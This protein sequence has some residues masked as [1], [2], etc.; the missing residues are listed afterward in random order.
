MR[1]HLLGVLSLMLAACGGGGAGG[2]SS[3][4]VGSE[5]VDVAACIAGNCNLSANSVAINSRNTILTVQNTRSMEA[6]VTL[7]NVGSNPAVA[8]M[9]LA[10]GASNIATGTLAT[11]TTSSIRLQNNVPS[12]V[13][14][15]NRKLASLLNNGQQA[16]SATSSGSVVQA[17]G[18]P[19]GPL[20]VGTSVAS[21]NAQVSDADAAFSSTLEGQ[22][23]LGNGQSVNVWVAANSNISRAQAQRMADIF[24]SQ[25]YNPVVALAGEPW[26]AV[27]TVAQNSL[28]A[29]GARDIHIV[30]HDITPDAQPL[31][32]I[33]Y[34]WGIN[35]FTR[36]FLLQHPETAALKSNEQL[37]FFMDSATYGYAG[38]PDPLNSN[39]KL[40]WSE[41]NP[42]P[43]IAIT[44]LAHEF[45]HMVQ[46][47]QK[48][49]RHAANPL[50]VPADDTWQNELASQTLA[51]VLGQQMYANQ[52]TGNNDINP[53]EMGY[54][55]PH[56][57]ASGEFARSLGYGGCLM[58]A[59]GE[60]S[61]DPCSAALHYPQAL[62]FGMYLVHQYGPGIL[63]EWI[64]SNKSGV[65]AIEAGLQAR[66]E[67]AGFYNVLKKWQQSVFLAANPVL[68]LPGYGFPARNDTVSGQNFALRA[69]YPFRY[70][71]TYRLDVSPLLSLPE[72]LTPYRIKVQTR[73]VS[74]DK[75]WLPANASLTLITDSGLVF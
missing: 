59:W 46:F 6:Y 65:A 27:P 62:S 14:T 18:V 11:Y 66:G 52:G 47:Y 69:V 34:F 44:T 61:F 43:A 17:S 54:Y 55:N 57:Y 48:V 1:K 58:T 68:N 19:A 10:E 40:L 41:T 7:R 35:N 49:V 29:G 22:A 51:Y 63:K 30:L 2:G 36:A 37:V 5:I 72:P 32:V 74:G 13:D 28:I 45:Q 26:G 8:M 25:I 12:K 24:A 50:P 4:T 20:T 16:D 73:V 42:T 67:T 33:G 71:K 23:V 38:D 31:G 3:N 9:S 70:S 60:S 53:S 64:T 39:N 15:F 21:W 56:L 75:I